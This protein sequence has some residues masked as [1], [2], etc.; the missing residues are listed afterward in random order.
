MIRR[1]PR[2]TR[3]DTLFPYTTLFRSAPARLLAF[4]A[5]GGHLAASLLDGRVE[6]FDLQQAAA[7]PRQFERDQLRAYAFAPHS[8]RLAIGA[9]GEVPLWDL[10]RSSW[11]WHILLPSSGFQLYYFVSAHVLI[12]VPT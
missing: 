3:T 8:E 10:Q 1:P 2:S 4:D 5:G 11:Q 12:P 9:H 6:L 7:V